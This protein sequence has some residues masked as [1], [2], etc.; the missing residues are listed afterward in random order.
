MLRLITKNLS[1]LQKAR[2][3]YKFSEIEERK[4]TAAQLRAQAEGVMAKKMLQNKY[5]M[6][7]CSP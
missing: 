5:K 2:I 7:N 6:I 3:K 1:Q 4:P